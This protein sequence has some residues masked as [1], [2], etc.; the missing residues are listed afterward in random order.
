MITKAIYAV[1]LTCAVGSLAV[2]FGSGVWSLIWADDALI[3]PLVAGPYAIIA[4][5]A[6]WWRAGRWEPLFLLAIA[7]LMSIGGLAAIGRS[8]YRFHAI[9]RDQTA[10]D[11]TAIV[12]PLAQWTLASGIAVILGAVAI[13][14][15]AAARSRP[16]NQRAAP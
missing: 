9:P 2:G 15:F 1:C 3:V 12:V 5:V 4:A 14:K 13:I 7:L 16:T 6:W 11:L 8:A 10:M